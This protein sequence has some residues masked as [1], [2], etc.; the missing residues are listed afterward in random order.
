[1]RLRRLKDIS[2]PPGGLHEEDV[3]VQKKYDGFK[4][5]ASTSPKKVKIYSRRGKDITQKV[6]PI[7]KELEK[8]LPGKT[9]VIGE[10]IYEKNGVQKLTDIQSVIQSSP[11]RAQDMITDLGGKIKFVIY[12][13]VELETDKLMDLPYEER[14]GYLEDLFFPSNGKVFLAKGYSWKQ[15]E[16]AIKESLLSGGEGIVIKSLDGEYHAK[17]LGASEPFGE[18]WKYKPPGKKFYTEDIYVKSYKKGKEK[19]IFDAYQR[20]NGKEIFVG[21]VSGLDKLT[22]NKIKKLVDKD[23]CPVLEVTY[24]DRMA[25]GK[26]RHMGYKRYRPDK[27][28]KSA[29]INPSMSRFEPMSWYV[30]IEDEDMVVLDSEWINPSMAYGRQL[31]LQGY[32]EDRPIKVLSEGAFKRYIKEQAKKLRPVK[33]KIG[34]SANARRS[35]VKEALAEE[36]LRYRDFENFAKAYWNNCARGIYWYPTDDRNFEIDKDAKDIAKDGDFYVYCTPD[37]SIKD[38]SAKDK[39]YLSEL[40]VN[41]LKP[42]DISIVRGSFG[43]KIKIKRV[44]PI[45]VLRTVTKN[46]AKKA[47]NWQRSILP[48]SKDELYEVWDKAW[49]KEEKRIEAERR[50]QERLE[51]AK[52]SKKRVKKK[53]SKKKRAKKNPSK[54]RKVAFNVNKPTLT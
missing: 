26:L 43:A 3:I 49:K 6:L 32:G 24:Q 9:T 15:R 7:A 35:L 48:S 5:M 40:N 30:V 20:K 44:E 47:F 18:Q 33:K 12:D 8:F 19:I 36:A 39:K 27:P 10:L 31:D 37:L 42:N 50:R 38:P 45:E 51:K 2:S 41:R 23:E 29:T 1:M 13:L 28:S 22:E 4:A 21:K 25:S 54:T 16:K 34:R 46:K 11:R 17:R 14:L 52:K 53:R